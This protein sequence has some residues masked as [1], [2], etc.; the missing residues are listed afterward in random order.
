MDSEGL[1]KSSSP[2]NHLLTNVVLHSSEDRSFCLSFNIQTD[3][4]VIA[5]Q[6]EYDDTSKQFLTKAIDKNYATFHDAMTGDLTWG[7]FELH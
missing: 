2:H 3:N 7:P 4:D 1:K 6:I 5:T